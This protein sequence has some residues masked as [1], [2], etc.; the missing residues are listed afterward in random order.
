MASW[1]TPG[2]PSCP[3]G[4]GTPANGWMDG[5]RHRQPVLE[6]HADQV[7]R[8]AGAHDDSSSARVTELPRTGDESLGPSAAEPARGEHTPPAQ[9]RRQAAVQPHLEPGHAQEQ[10][11]E[12]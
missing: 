7:A 4:T 3:F 5:G 9:P 2:T 8:P 12:D 6:P 10:A 1:V 11:G